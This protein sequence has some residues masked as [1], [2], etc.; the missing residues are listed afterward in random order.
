MGRSV[1]VSIVTGC[2]TGGDPQY[3]MHG[4]AAGGATTALPAKT[5]TAGNGGERAQGGFAAT[6]TGPI[7]NQVLS[8]MNPN[9]LRDVVRALKRI[10]AKDPERALR[11][12]N[13]NPQLAYALVQT[14]QMLGLIGS[15]VAQQLF[16]T[17]P[18]L[19]SLQPPQPP[20]QQQAVPVAVVSTA[21]PPQPPP[22]QPQPELIAYGGYQP[23][24]TG[25]PVTVA[26]AAPPQQQVY[27]ETVAPDGTAYQVPQYV[28]MQPPEVTDPVLQYRM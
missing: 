5:G 19:P 12:L 20:P 8:R 27:L 10:D 6:P 1:R 21:P 15:D 11:L 24:V 14:L 23:A 4:N 25:V 3:G 26:V 28:T 18:P 7:I 16:T 2:H 13:D 17:G 9:V 22:P